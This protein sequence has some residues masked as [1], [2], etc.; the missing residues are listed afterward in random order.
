M[1]K[2][3]FKRKKRALQNQSD[4]RKSVDYGNAASKEK[5]KMTMD[6]YF[7][8]KIRIFFVSSKFLLAV[9]DDLNR[10]RSPDYRW[11]SPGR[12]RS[13]KWAGKGKRRE[14]PLYGIWNV[15]HE[16]AKHRDNKREKETNRKKLLR[17]WRKS[18][19][20]RFSRAKSSKK[21]GKT[22]VKTFT[23]FRGIH[24]YF[25]LLCFFSS[26]LL[27]IPDQKTNFYR[28]FIISSNLIIW[29]SA[30]SDTVFQKRFRGSSDKKQQQG[31]DRIGR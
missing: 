7:A 16:Y 1:R 4:E 31:R 28:F 30:V 27:D 8:R 13:V 3:N 21:E 6:F 29:P 22:F 2:K 10:F 24:P 11:Y 26:N 19:I 17:R 25:Q 20:T 9:S 12:Y 5:K 18:E 14:R 23:L 15:G